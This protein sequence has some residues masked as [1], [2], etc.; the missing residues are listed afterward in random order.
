M[1]K[2]SPPPAGWYDF[3]GWV[4]TNKMRVAMGAGVAALIA[5][6][7][8]LWVWRNSEREIKAEEALSAVLVPFSPTEQPARGT[9]EAYL[10]IAEEYPKTKAA[11]KALLRAGTVFFDQGDYTKA[12][13]QFQKL[14]RNYGDTL[15]VPQAV[16]GVA[17]CLDAQN[18]TADA[19]TRYSDFI[20]KYPSDP[21]NEQARFN[22]A[23]LFDQTR[24][25]ALALDVLRKMSDPQA[26]GPAMQEAQEKIRELVAKYPSLIPSNPV[27]APNIFTNVV[28]PQTNVLNLSNLIHRTT[29][30]MPQTNV[31]SLSN[32]I[33]LT[34]SALNSTGAPPRILL[35]PGNTNV[36]K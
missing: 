7:I 22:L 6:V 19:I 32:L 18:K 36:P 25:P 9:A 3:L 31:L 11:A 10:K 35:S 21:A 1:E 23:R 4:E 16:F 26:P 34:N 14:L 12:Q 20:S 8:G 13:E 5:I 27:T 24:Q 33:R 28:R 2:S 30:L 29:N 17:A 15:W